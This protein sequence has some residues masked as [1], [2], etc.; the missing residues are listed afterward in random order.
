MFLD[1]PSDDETNNKY[2]NGSDSDRDLC[3]NL[4]I[5]GIVLLT[6]TL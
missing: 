4:S 6:T 2:I 1:V 5:R 3:L